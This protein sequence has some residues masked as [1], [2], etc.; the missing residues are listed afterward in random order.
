MGP[1]KKGRTAKDRIALVTATAVAG[2]L[3]LAVVPFAAS[4]SVGPSVTLTSCPTGKDPYAAGYDPVNHFVYV[5]NFGSGNVTVLQGMCTQVATITLPSGAEPAAAAF[6]P[7]NDHVYVTDYALDQVYEILTTTVTATLTSSQLNGP[8]GITYDPGTG[9][10]A[11]ANNLG[12]TMSIITPSGVF[13][14]SAPVG[15]SPLFIGFDPYYDTLLVTNE[16]SANVSVFNASNLFHVRDVPVGLS[17]EGIAYDPADVTDY[18]ACYGSNNVSLLY[19]DGSTVSSIAGLSSPEGVVFDQATLHIYVT[20]SGNGK[21]TIISGQTV[22]GT[23]ATTPG[24]GVISAAYDDTNDK[25]YVS[26]DY[27]STVY[28]LS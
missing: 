20:N 27:T 25:V 19:G 13:A 14:A 28:V 23:K 16:G 8:V 1:W 21:V 9:F 5:P 3:L 4:L 2:V 22:V 6:D 7:T 24:S 15:T 26:G 18:I 17:P 10:M 11:V 12:N